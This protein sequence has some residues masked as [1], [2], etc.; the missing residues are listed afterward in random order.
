M[1]RNGLYLLTAVAIYGVDVEVGVFLILRD[2]KIHGGDSTY[3]TR[4]RMT[5]QMANG[6]AK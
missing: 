1:I 2:G 4:G 6:R 3:I 5:A